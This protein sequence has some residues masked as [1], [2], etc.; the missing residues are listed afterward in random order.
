MDINN[1]VCTFEAV[2]HCSIA[3]SFF[4]IWAS[5]TIL[6]ARQRGKEQDLED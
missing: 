1:Y 5:L 6:H 3:V 2:E 4:V